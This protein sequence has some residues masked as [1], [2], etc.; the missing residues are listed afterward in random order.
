[1]NSVRSGDLILMFSAERNLAIEFDSMGRARR[2]LI[3]L[4]CQK[5]AKKSVFAFTFSLLPAS[6]F[7]L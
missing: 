6:F 3:D 2:D 1:M 4:G 5:V 7:L